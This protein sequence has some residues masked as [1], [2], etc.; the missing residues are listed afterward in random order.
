M[1]A[2]IRE[3]LIRVL[4]DSTSAEEAMAKTELATGKTSNAGGV[5]SKALADVKSKLLGVVPGGQAAEGQ[6]TKVGKSAEEAG[7]SLGGALTAGVAA[8]GVAIT[9]LA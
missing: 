5:L 8:A 6:M 7:G 3:L 2:N 9:A 4:G 1:G